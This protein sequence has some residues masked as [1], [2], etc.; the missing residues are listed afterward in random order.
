VTPAAL[1]SA[2]SLIPLSELRARTSLSVLE[3]AVG[4]GLAAAVVLFTFARGRV[5]VVLPA[6]VFLALAS[7]SFAVSQDVVTQS[8]AQQ[9]RLLG[10]VRR[11]VDRTASGPVAYIYDGSTWWNAVWE[12]M[13]WNRS[14]RWV[15]DLPGT[16][17]P[18]P[19]PQQPLVVSNDGELRPNG[20]RSPARYAVVPLDFALRGTLVAQ[21]P[22]LGTDRQGLGLWRL[23]LPLRISTI[24]A[25]LFQNGDI[26]V[27]ASVAAYGCQAGTFEAVLL[28]KQPQTVVVSLDGRRVARKRFPFATT[29]DLRL[30]VRPTRTG[31]DRICRLIVQSN[32]LLGSTQFA[33]ERG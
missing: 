26:D 8:R 6:V 2:F 31:S 28:V 7:A 21:A 32:G 4:L 23:D 30:P 17:V 11:W 12:N 15:Y 25:G 24:T 16:S 13:F 22:Q 1:P 3:L 10:P 5:H 29:W 19:V 9:L 33:F 14:I 27:V 18:G 20:E